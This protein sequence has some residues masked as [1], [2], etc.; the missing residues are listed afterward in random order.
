M[1]LPSMHSGA[2][3]HRPQTR[4]ALLVSTFLSSTFGALA[5]G[6][7][8]SPL[9][10]HVLVH[11]RRDHVQFVVPQVAVVTQCRA[12]VGVSEHALHGVDVRSR[13]DR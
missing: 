5:P 12:R 8:P 4:S 11:P 10:L 9:G 13:V 6:A 2:R 3:S 7:E 1:A